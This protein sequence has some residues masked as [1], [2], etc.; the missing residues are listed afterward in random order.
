M[1]GARTSRIA[2]LDGQR[3]D[4][5]LHENN[6]TLGTVRFGQLVCCESARF[7]KAG[8]DVVQNVRPDLAD[9]CVK[10]MN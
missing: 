1:E 4:E 8:I 6:V 3:V 9:I 7:N 5:Q 2:R 10:R